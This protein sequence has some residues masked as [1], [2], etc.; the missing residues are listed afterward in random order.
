LSTEAGLTVAFSI[1]SFTLL[2]ITL[3]IIRI[4]TLNCQERAEELK[5]KIG[6]DEQ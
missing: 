3:L 2:F 4:E 6:G 1:A 5:R